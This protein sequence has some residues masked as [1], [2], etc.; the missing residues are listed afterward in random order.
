MTERERD[1]QRMWLMVLGTGWC[2]TWATS[3]L[4]YWLSEPSGEGF[5]RG[6][7]R[8]L[9]FLGWQGV[10]GMFALALWG[11]ARNWPK[12]NATRRIA[13]IPAALTL[14]LITAIVLLVLWG[15]YL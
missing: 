8:V 4:A 2:L 9:N 13:S 14:L 12:G 15:A 1:R 6:M 3:F 11:V 5:L 10:A 7:N